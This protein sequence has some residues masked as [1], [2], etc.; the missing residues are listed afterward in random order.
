[1]SNPWIGAWRIAVVPAFKTNYDRQPSTD[2]SYQVMSRV[3]YDPQPPNGLDRSLQNY[4]QAASS[5]RA[6]IVGNVF[7]PVWSDD[8]DTVG[9]AIRSLPPNHGYNHILVVLPHS[10]GLHRRPYALWDGSPLNG[11]TAWAR[12]AMYENT[13]LTQ[14]QSIGV[15]AMEVLHMTTELADLY[16]VA[17]HLGRYDVMADAYASSHPSA[18]TKRIFGWVPANAVARHSA[19]S[20][21]YQ[22]HA[23]GLP[24]PPPPGRVTAVDIPARGSPNRFLIEARR[25]VDQYERSDSGGDGIPQEGVIVYE[26]ENETNVYLRTL[27]ALQPGQTYSNTSAGFDIRVAN[28]FPGGY[29]VDVTTTPSSDCPDILKQIEVLEEAIDRESNFQ[30]KRLLI[31]RL[32]ALVFRARGQGCY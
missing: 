26:V 27:T 19:G 32:N 30:R 16:N 15:W 11:I 14:P 2:W 8:D 3:F 13:G 12:V 7:P 5:G 24:Q 4:I 20:S 25:N 10:L 22:L 28:A 1:M 6:N 9:K 23:V 31:I 17:P 29:G 21:G 18:H